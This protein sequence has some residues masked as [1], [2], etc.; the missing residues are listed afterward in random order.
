M[1]VQGCVTDFVKSITH[2]V[3]AGWPRHVAGR[4]WSSA[5]TNLQLGIL[6]YCLLESVT[7]KPTRERQQGGVGRPGVLAGQPPPGPT[8]QQ[9]L[10]IA[11]SC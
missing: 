5:S 7:M 1:G 2:Q 8:S 6:L 9:P 11:F 10:H 3:V 4:P